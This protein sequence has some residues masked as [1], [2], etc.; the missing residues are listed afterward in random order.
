MLRCLSV[1]DP[2]TGFLAATETEVP[3]WRKP[4]R[5]DGECLPARP[6]NPA[7]H[8]NAFVLVVVCLPKSSSV[9]DDCVVAANLRELP[10]LDVVFR[11]RQCDK[12]NHRWREGLPLT[13]ALPKF[14]S[15]GR[16][17]PSRQSP[18]QTKKRIPLSVEQRE[19]LIRGIGQLFSASRKLTRNGDLG[20]VPRTCIGTRKSL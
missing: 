6:T 9:P 8:P 17:S 4:V 14:R 12:E 2:R 10:R 18:I 13:V 15:A 5:Q 11:L 20:S 19:P 16:P 7:P 3:R 1:T